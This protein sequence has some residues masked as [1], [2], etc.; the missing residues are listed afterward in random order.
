M[1]RLKNILRRNPIRLLLG[2][3]SPA[4]VSAVVDPSALL[5]TEQPVDEPSPEPPAADRSQGA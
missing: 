5:A 1:S 4:A 2:S 3:S